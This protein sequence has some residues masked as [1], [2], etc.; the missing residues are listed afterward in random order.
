MTPSRRDFLRT[1]S[2]AGTALALGP[3][4][5]VASQANA[6][7]VPA[8]TTSVAPKK[9][10]IL[11]GTGFIGPNMVK[12]AL[13]R[14]HE[15][16]ILTRG[17]SATK[18]DGVEHI[19]ADREGDLGMLSKR[20]WDVVLDNNARDYRW[21]TRSVKA[22]KDST[23]HY[24]FVSSISAYKTPGFSYATAGQ[25]RTVPVE[26]SFERF[27]PA[28]D[29]K[30]GV[31][32]PYGLS[33]AMSENFVHANFPSGT[34]VVRPGLIVGPGDPTDRFT[35]WPVRIDEGGEVLAPGNPDHASQVIDQRDLTEWIVRLAENGVKG[36]FNATGP[37]TRMSM[38]EMLAGCR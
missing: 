34:T 18:V 22:L 10:L 32:A 9:L 3:A 23:G 15:V 7:S 6:A 28:G 5:R 11:G 19:T 37:G 2:L 14:G 35:Y 24:L 33:K 4:V 20:K 17:R 36:D 26:E 25:V 13:A 30:D 12:Y 29:F 31:E 8:P 1:T 16:T 21:V 27:A 38:L